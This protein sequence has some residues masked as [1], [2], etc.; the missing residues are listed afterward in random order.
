MF[1]FTKKTSLSRQKLAEV[2]Q[3]P[4]E[5]LKEI[6]LSVSVL[7][8]ETKEWELSVSHDYQFEMNNS[9]LVKRQELVWRSKEEQFAEMEAEKPTT[10]KAE[11]SGHSKRVRKRSIREAKD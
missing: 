3:L 8:M 4:A 6:L 1:Q 2:T 9:D 10:S 7:N 11:P 5:E